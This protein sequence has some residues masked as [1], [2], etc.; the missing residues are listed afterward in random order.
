MA[1]YD[2]ARLEAISVQIMAAAIS[3]DNLRLQPVNYAILA[4]ASIRAAQVLI[5]ELDAQP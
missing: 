3:R 2:P 5:L 1:A 4:K